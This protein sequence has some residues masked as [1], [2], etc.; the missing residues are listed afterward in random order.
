MPKPSFFVYLRQNR[1]KIFYRKGGVGD[2]IKNG[3][4]AF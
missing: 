4:K 3:K 2:W 1:E